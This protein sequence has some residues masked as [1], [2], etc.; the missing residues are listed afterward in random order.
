MELI[1]GIILGAIIGGV[2]LYFYLKPK[3]AGTLWVD[4]TNA[5][6]LG[7]FLA[8]STDGADVIKHTKFVTFEVSTVKDISQK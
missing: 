6:D 3:T 2:V 7:L 4:K 1:I 5:N 8:L